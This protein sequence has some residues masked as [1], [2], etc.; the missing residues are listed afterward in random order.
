MPATTV[1]PSKKTK[2]GVEAKVNVPQKSYYVR[3]L[4][5]LFLL[6]LQRK[7]RRGKDGTNLISRS[8][9][10]YVPP[11]GLCLPIVSSFSFRLSSSFLF[12]QQ[13]TSSLARWSRGGEINGKRRKDGHLYLIFLAIKQAKE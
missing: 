7:K 4:F 10:L 5:L 8:C 12:P 3:P 6:L 2:K 13:R 9:L 1:V 11:A